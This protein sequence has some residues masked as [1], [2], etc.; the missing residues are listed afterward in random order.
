MAAGVDPAGIGGALPGFG[1]QRNYELLLEA[2]FTPE[3]VVQIMTLNGARVLGEADRFGSIE[4]SKLANLVVING[5][6]VD[7]HTRYATSRSC[8]RK[9]SDTTRQN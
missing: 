8:S 7:A 3:Q 6:P 5:D 1:D 2:G 9:G 4:E